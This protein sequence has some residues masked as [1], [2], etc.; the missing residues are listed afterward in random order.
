M[1][2]N[3]I[4]IGGGSSGLMAACTAAE[5]GATVTLLEK[6][7]NLAIRSPNEIAVVI[8]C[9]SAGTTA[10]TATSS[11]GVSTSVSLVVTK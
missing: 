6:N 8:K 2:K 4:V 1:R 9:K 11:A 3:V 5:K 7:P 10:L